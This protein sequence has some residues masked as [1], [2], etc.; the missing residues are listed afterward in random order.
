MTEIEATR[1]PA[2]AC[3]GLPPEAVGLSSGALAHLAYNVGAGDLPLPVATLSRSALTHNIETMARW[4]ARHGVLLAPHG[5]T[6]LSPDLFRRQ[7]TAGAWGITVTTAHHAAVAASAGVR[8]LIVANQLVDPVGLRILASLADRCELEVYVFVDSETGLRR[9]EAAEAASTGRFHALIELGLHGGRTGVRDED[10]FWRLLAAADGS[11]VP[12]AGVSAFEG[13]IPITRPL[14][15]RNT[16][17]AAEGIQRLRRYLAQV[18]DA[19]AHARDRGLLARDSLVTAGGSSAFDQVV[20]YLGPLDGE[21]ILRSGCYVTHDHGMYAMQSPLQEGNLSGADPAEMLR[22][23]LAVW[24]HVISTPEPGAA[25]VGLGRRDAGHDAGMPA[26]L[27]RIAGH[28]TDE[29][30]T[31]WTPIKMW[32]QHTLLQATPAATP[33]TVGDV[34]RFGISH[35]CTTFDKWRTLVEIDDQN[36]VVGRLDTSF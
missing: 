17:A 12:V 33:L 6:T 21:L 1:V 25:V 7:L 36:T 20:E 24:A 10:A 23:A 31:G 9:L 34:L 26:P 13:L 28:G 3:K 35:P 8:R 14:D 11:P 27:G 5:K 29:P 30:V 4:C 15:S 22:P 16:A 18:A 19:I 32:D 2:V